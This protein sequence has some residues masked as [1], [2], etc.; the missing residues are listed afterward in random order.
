MGHVSPSQYNKYAECSLAY[1]FSYILK[2]KMPGNTNLA[3]GSS[4]HEVAYEVAR[5]NEQLSP[6][7]ITAIYARTWASEMERA[8]P[9][10]G[11]NVKAQY[12]KGLILSQKFAE[13]YYRGYFGITPLEFLPR[14]SEETIPALE[15]ECDFLPAVDFRTGELLDDDTTLFVKIDVIGTDERDMLVI[16]DHKTAG[17]RYGEHKVIKDQQMLFYNAAFIGMQAMGMFPGITQRSADELMYGVALKTKKSLTSDEWDDTFIKYSRPVTNAQMD[18][19]FDNLK[20]AI[21]GMKNGPYIACPSNVCSYCS[22][23]ILCDAYMNGQDPVEA[24]EE[25]MDTIS[26]GKED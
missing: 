24:H 16:E 2:L 10:E 5:R 17:Q 7:Q 25:Y 15:L 13:G 22:H 11:E 23:R 26:K 6:E 14:D 12:E 4:Y 19:F 1:Y 3:L 8:V 9:K 21:K 20:Q 18:F